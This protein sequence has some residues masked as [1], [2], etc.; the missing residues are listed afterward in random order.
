MIGKHAR[1]KARRCAASLSP[2]YNC[3]IIS[4]KNDSVFRPAKITTV[5]LLL[6]IAL[7]KA[8][9]SDQQRRHVP[10]SPTKLLLARPPLPL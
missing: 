3:I 10:M 7:S 8:D 2:L 5:R 4:R 9:T 1:L 6:V